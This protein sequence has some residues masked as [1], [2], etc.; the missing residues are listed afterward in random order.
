MA[1]FCLAL[2]LKDLKNRISKIIVAY[3]HANKPVYVKDLKIVGAVMKILENAINP[4]VVQ[5]LEGNLA[6]V[7]GGPFANIAHGCNSILATKTAMNIADYTVTEAGFASDLGAEKFLDIVCDVAQ[8]KPNAI[9]IVTS[10]RSLKMHGGVAKENLKT[11]NIKALNL[12]IENLEAHIRNIREF[13]IPFIVSITQLDISFSKEIEVV[14]K[15]LEN[16]RIEYALNGSFEFGSS[17][18]VDLAKKVIKLCDKKSKLNMVYDKKQT[19]DKK[20][21]L[22]CRRCY[23]ASGVE[24]SEEADKKLKILM[25]S[26]SYVCIAKTPASLT[27]DEKV[28][29]ID[30]PFKIHVKDLIVANGSDFIIV[31]TGN[32]FRMPG[33][34][35]IPEANNM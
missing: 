29:Y 30:K 6:L 25:N 18:A 13:G 7:H 17:A 4:N 8:I 19:L 28:L 1:I 26:K 33:L 34:P 23:G 10:T 24:Y 31:M 9:V 5:S 15:W 32:V 35:K 12:G 2:N 21:D 3:T 16:N 11:E 14:K 22:I 20:I 27:D